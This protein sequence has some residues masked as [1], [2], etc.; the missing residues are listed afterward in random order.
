MKYIL[1]SGSP[2]KIQSIKVINVTSEDE[3][4]MF[5]ENL[6]GEERNERPVTSTN[7]KDYT[8]TVYSAGIWCIPEEEDTFNTYR[9]KIKYYWG[10]QRFRRYR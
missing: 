5:L 4:L 9:V 6:F 2:L 3:A 1:G 7:F 10:E 8:Y